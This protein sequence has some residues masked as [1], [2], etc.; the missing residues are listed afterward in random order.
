MT[1][2]LMENVLKYYGVY[3]FL[4]VYTCYYNHSHKINSICK[5]YFIFHK[6]F[7]C[8]MDVLAY[9]FTAAANLII[10][11]RHVL[12]TASYHK[13]CDSFVV[14][15]LRYR[16]VIHACMHILVEYYDENIF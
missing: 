10:R 5:E 15:M 3:S 13:C 9:L 16:C 8:I 6:Y 7:I 11:L 2:L 1:Y 14:F 12:K 4:L